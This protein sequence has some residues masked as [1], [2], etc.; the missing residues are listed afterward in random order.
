LTVSAFITMETAGQVAVIGNSY[1]KIF[2][3]DALRTVQNSFIVRSNPQ[4]EELSS[5]VAF[6][7]NF[8][9]ENN[10]SLFALNFATLYE[11]NQ[12]FSISAN[13]AL[14]SLDTFDSLKRIGAGAIIADNVQ[15]AEIKG[16]NA[17]KYIGSTCVIAANT[18]AMSTNAC[19]SSPS[20]SCN[21]NFVPT[22]L[23]PI[24]TTITSFPIDSGF[25]VT[26]FDILALDSCNYGLEANF[27]LL[28][29]NANSTCLSN[30]DL[31]V[32]SASI[33]NYSLIIYGNSRLRAIGGFSNLKHIESVLFI[34]FNAVLHT[35]N[36]FGQLAFALDIWIRNN[37]SIKYIIGFNN[38]L[39]IR[40]LIL[41]ESV[42]LCDWNN[43]ACLEYAQ[44]IAI[45]S[46]TA[47]AVKFGKNHSVPS[48]LGYD[49][50]YSFENKC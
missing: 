20:C 9:V 25:D 3:L 27:Y 37:P 15:L 30:A 14:L 39:S 38:L 13:C 35:I 12:Q 40:N 50:Y 5:S 31:P 47:K 4:L 6:V 36:A 48:V 49:L 29:C 19:M 22:V 1:L 28:V 18:I 24:C 45:E 23:K 8:Y 44:D 17:L 10:K 42:C 7:D 33:V 34:I 46:K 11:V 16:F 32:A 43:L 2:K 41:L 21:V 26:A